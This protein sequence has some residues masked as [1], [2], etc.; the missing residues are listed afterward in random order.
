M[1]GNV[2]EWKNA[3]HRAAP[4]CP[5][6]TRFRRTVLNLP[7]NGATSDAWPTPA[8]HRG[9]MAAADNNRIWGAA[10]GRFVSATDTETWTIVLAIAH[11]LPQ[12]FWGIFPSHAAQHAEPNIYLMR[13]GCD[14]PGGQRTATRLSVVK[15]GSVSRTLKTPPGNR[16]PNRELASSF[17]ALIRL[18]KRA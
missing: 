16:D 18:P 9:H 3:M 7:L 11:P 14:A 15:A 1:A 8:A 10:R 2:R 5:A 17:L 12:T 6:R 13:A 4:A